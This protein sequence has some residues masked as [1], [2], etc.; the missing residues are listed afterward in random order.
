[1]VGVF[2]TQDWVKIRG[3]QLL[4]HDGYYDLRITAELWETQFYDYLALTT[5]DHPAATDIWVDERFSVPQQ[6]PLK[7][8]IT[9]IARPIARATDDTGQD[10]TATVKE[11][12]GRY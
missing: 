2:Q 9:A 5:V 8:Y 7:I 4:P 1:M 11:R 3:D 12:D 6:P 10:V